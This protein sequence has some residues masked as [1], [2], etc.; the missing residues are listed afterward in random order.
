M[1]QQLADVPPSRERH[2]SGSRVTIALTRTAVGGADQ[3][4]APVRMEA[5]NAETLATLAEVAKSLS[6]H[7]D[8]GFVSPPW[9]GLP[10]PWRDTHHP[11]EFRQA[12]DWTCSPLDDAF[13]SVAVTD[14][15]D[16]VIRWV[17]DDAT[18]LGGR[19]HFYLIRRGDPSSGFRSG[20]PRS[21]R[22]V[23]TSDAVTN[24]DDDAE[25]A[26]PSLSALDIVRADQERP[27]MTIT[28][29]EQ[30]WRS[31]KGHWFV[32]TVVACAALVFGLFAY[33]SVSAAGQQEVREAVA[34]A[35]WTFLLVGV[36][37]YFVKALVERHQADVAKRELLDDYRKDIIDRVVAHLSCPGSRLHRRG[38]PFPADLLR[39]DAARLA[40]ALR[41]RTAHS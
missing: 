10:E 18:C 39:A 1:R 4:S 37:S 24:T 16:V 11:G 15:E 31:R 41:A 32:V 6:W 21:R 13:G 38:R 35:S 20:L 27:L 3:Q 12:R 34:K 2:S 9:S 22:A 30:W 28:Q 36:L 8:P 25:D 26:T 33:L 40:L 29:R 17:S 5:P 7:P 14:G 19:T 23:N